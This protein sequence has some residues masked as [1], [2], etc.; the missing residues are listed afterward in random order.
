MTRTA[1]TFDAT[2]ENIKHHRI[3]IIAF[4]MQ[5]VCWRIEN[6]SSAKALCLLGAFIILISISSQSE[7]N[8]F[9]S[10]EIISVEIQS[11][12]LNT[13]REFRNDHKVSLPFWNLSSSSKLVKFNWHILEFN[14]ILLLLFGSSLVFFIVYIFHWYYCWWKCFIL[15]E[16][17][18]FSLS[19]IF[20]VSFYWFDSWILLLMANYLCIIQDV[21]EISWTFT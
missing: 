18:E 20:S 1:K 13:F 3:M 5:F 21:E 7:I 14:Q 2:N 9:K 16:T 12:E 6:E 15:I 17:K 19:R 4:L 10:S 11:Y 8:Q